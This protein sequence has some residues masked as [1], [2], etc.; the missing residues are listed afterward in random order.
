MSRTF[1]ESDFS[2]VRGSYRDHAARER[3]RTA[4]IEQSMLLKKRRLLMQQ[5]AKLEAQKLIEEQ[6]IRSR[7]RPLKVG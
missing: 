7:R 2:G 5:I 6:R 1:E 4:R 3:L